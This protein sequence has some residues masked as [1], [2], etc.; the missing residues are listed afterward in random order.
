[1]MDKREAR[2]R[3]FARRLF[4][5]ENLDGVRMDGEAEWRRFLDAIDFAIETNQRG[6]TVVEDDGEHRVIPGR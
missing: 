4:D 2:A 6:Y 3:A 1:M 5:V